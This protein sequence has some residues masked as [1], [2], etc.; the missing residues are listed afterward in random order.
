MHIAA[1]NGNR[2]FKSEALLTSMPQYVTAH[3]GGIMGEV[4]GVLQYFLPTPDCNHAG[5][6]SGTW[7]LMRPDKLGQVRPC[8]HVSMRCAWLPAI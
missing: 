7:K 2:H 4:Y 1:F 8:G 3:S 6:A 5:K